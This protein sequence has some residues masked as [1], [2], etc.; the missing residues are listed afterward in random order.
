MAC[1]SH[2]KKNAIGPK[3]LKN[4]KAVLFVQAMEKTGAKSLWTSYSKFSFGGKNSKLQ[5]KILT[6][7][8]ILLQMLYAYMVPIQIF[9]Q[10]Q[11]IIFW[12][13]HVLILNLLGG[14]L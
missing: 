9:S 7:S 10:I 12:R 11:L 4:E 8:T 3:M 1:V 6:Q 5:I 2:Y 13:T 14:K